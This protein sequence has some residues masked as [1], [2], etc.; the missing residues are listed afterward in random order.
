M[1]RAPHIF[2]PDIRV[3]L[4]HFVARHVQRLV[5]A[6]RGFDKRRGRVRC[7]VW[8]A[9]DQ[10]DEFGEEGQGDEHGDEAG[11]EGEEEGEVGVFEEGLGVT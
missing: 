9:G 10:G 3:D 5:H 2:V 8:E 11:E 4:E 7:V 1:R 6:V